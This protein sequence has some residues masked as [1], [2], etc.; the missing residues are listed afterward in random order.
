MPGGKR[1]AI[2]P[3]TLH[4]GSPPWALLHTTIMLCTPVLQKSFFFFFFLIPMRYCDMPNVVTRRRVFEVIGSGGELMAIPS[5][6]DFQASS[7]SR[8][9]LA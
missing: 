3:A 9:T 1:V 8:L 6:W 2:R 7:G 4:R 5:R